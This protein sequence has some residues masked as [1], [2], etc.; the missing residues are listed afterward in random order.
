MKRPKPSRQGSTTVEED[1]RLT[2]QVGYWTDTDNDRD[3]Y[4]TD[5]CIE[6]IDEI[7][8]GGPVP[9]WLEELIFDQCEEVLIDACA[10]AISDDVDDKMVTRYET[11]QDAR[12]EEI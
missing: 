9:R 5:L 12:R 8:T 10:D 11:I 6:S 7:P 2:V 3:Y 4:A 1:V